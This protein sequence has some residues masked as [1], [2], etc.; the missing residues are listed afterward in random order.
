MIDA[1]R[2][3]RQ[4]R[5][6]SALAVL[7]AAALW[8]P[9]AS[10]QFATG[11]N[12]LYRPQIFW[13]DFGNNGDNVYAGATVTRGFNVD[14]PASAANR[15]NITCSIANATATAGAT[16]LFVYTP[17]TWQGDGLDNLY[18]IGGFQNGSGTNPN[19]LSNGLSVS[20]GATVEFDFTCSATLGGLPFTLAGLVFA[21]AEASGGAEYVAARLTNGGTLRVIDQISQCGTSSTVNVAGTPTEVRFNGPTAPQTSCEANATPTLRAGPALVGFIDGATSGRVIAKGGGISAVAVGT[22]LSLEF[23]EAIPASYGNAAHVLNPSFNGGVATTGVNYNNPAN[24]ATLSVGAH[25][26]ATV[27]ADADANGAIGGSD[28]DALPKTTGPAGAGY[29]NVPPPQN[30]PGSTYTI[31][32]IPCTG[33]GSV[34]GWIDFNGN[35]AFDTTERSAVATC[36]AGNNTINLSWTI[37]AAGFVPQA[38]SYLRLRLATAAAGVAVATGPATGGEAED[39]RFVL[40]GDYGDA[41]DNAAGTAIGDYSTRAADN[42]PVH[43]IPAL[44]TVYLGSVAPDGDSGSLQNATATADDTT[45]S[46]DEDGLAGIPATA[47]KGQTYNLTV[48][49]VGSG[50][51]NAWIDWN[52]D[53]DFVDAGEQIANGQ[54]LSGGASTLAITVPNAASPGVTFIRLR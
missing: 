4:F 54:A 2:N 16:G 25:L 51:L 43:A 13:V 45:G 17:G 15:L 31:P 30:V 11:G 27:V 41:P 36:P 21:D 9:G 19:T 5:W 47:V 40:L 18:N 28:V 29:A 48:T 39:Y 38:T 53:G 6:M 52:R 34:A 37:P 44:P 35:G 14:T 49:T 23:S 24:L 3:T 50:F 33:P 12:G 1:V 20:N 26:G 42:G 22:F 10:A 32:N 8:A 7:C 46:D